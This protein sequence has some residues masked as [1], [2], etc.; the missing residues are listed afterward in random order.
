MTRPLKHKN[1]DLRGTEIHR[2]EALVVTCIDFRLTDAVSS[3]LKTR[4]LSGDYD[5]VSIAGAALGIMSKEKTAWSEM[6]WDHL[7][8]AREM[9]SIRKVIVIDHRDCGACKKFMGK[10][11]AIDPAAELTTHKRAMNALADE[12]ELRQPGLQIELLFM[13]LEGKV[14]QL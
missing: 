9:H 6:F 1:P 2:A 5:H 8:L 10:D 13:D 12:I 14:L 4:G 11:C 3:Y 7:A